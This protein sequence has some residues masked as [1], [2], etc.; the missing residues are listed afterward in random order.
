MIISSTVGGTTDPTGEVHVEPGLSLE[1]TAESVAGYAF[2][3]WLFDGED[4]G[5]D[6]PIT[7]PA[8]DNGSSHSLVAQF[9]VGLELPPLISGVMMIPRSQGFVSPS[10]TEEAHVY[11]SPAATEAISEVAACAINPSVWTLVI[12][13]I[14]SSSAGS[15]APNGVQTAGSGATIT[16][17]AS[18]GQFWAIKTSS[19]W[20]ADGAPQT[21]TFSAN[22]ATNTYVFP[23]QTLGTTHQLTVES[24]YGWELVVTG[25]T[26]DGTTDFPSGGNSVVFTKR[27]TVPPEVFDGWFLDNVYKTAIQRTPLSR[28]RLGLLTR[29][30]R[31]STR[32]NSNKSVMEKNE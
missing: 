5:T 9:Q 7:I 17:I 32:P 1:V 18:V 11:N 31:G 28:K 23:T 15:V 10:I 8:Q 12:S 4:A 25:S 13:M 19:P 26:A 30:K 16:V 22:R 27:A 6:N 29:L 3:G 20:N 21:G 2:I 24:Q 14:P